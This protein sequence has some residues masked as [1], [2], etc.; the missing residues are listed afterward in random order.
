MEAGEEIADEGESPVEEAPESRP[1]EIKVAIIGRP[2]VGKS[3]LL[4]QL[5]GT[6]RAIVSPVAGTTRDSIDELVE[7][8]G[9][10]VPLRR[11]G[12]NPPQGQ[13]PADGREA[14]RGDGPQGIWKPPTSC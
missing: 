10:E 3:T 11:H 2:N 1:D 12:R 9:F 8:D 14:L 7:R 6:S 4:N 13:D 5:T